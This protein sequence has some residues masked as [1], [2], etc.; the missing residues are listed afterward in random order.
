MRRRKAR[1]WSIRR[2]IAALLLCCAL[3]LGMVWM[4][5]MLKVGRP[6]SV[7]NPPAEVIPVQPTIELARKSLTDYFAAER[8]VDKISCLHDGQRVGE[9]WRQYYHERGK[10]FPLLVEI[11]SA[12]LAEK[13]GRI[14]A[15]F[16]VRLSPGG[17]QPL[18]MI[19][20]DDR[21]RLEWESQV[22]YGTM[23]WIEWVE[24]KPP[25]PQVM[26]IYLSKA[27]SGPIAGD[28]GSSRSIVV[29]EHRDS[30]GPEMARVAPTVE[31]DLD[32]SGRQR[33]PVTAEFEFKREA[34]TPRLHLTRLI[35]EG[36]SR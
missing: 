32:F 27:P 4:I 23:D 10:P 36:W 6:A 22:A 17:R 24:S 21:F 30:L 12:T 11:L 7:H 31:F 18:A 14:L 3:A 26:R 25:S 8:E 33:V 1:R 29:V 28:E 5:G 35:H 2:F 13:G 19:W 16:E 20:E 15:L 9:L 34:G